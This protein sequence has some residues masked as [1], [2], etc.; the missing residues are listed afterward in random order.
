MKID[1]VDCLVSVTNDDLIDGVFI[2]PNGVASFGDFAFK[3]ATNLTQ[4]DIPEWVTSIDD[5]VFAN[6]TLLV[7]MII[8]N[9]VTEMGPSVFDNCTSLEQITISEAITIIEFHT[10]KGC[11]SLKQVN[12]PGKVNSIGLGA[13][14]GCASLEQVILPDMLTSLGD[15]VFWQCISLKRMDIPRGVSAIEDTTFYGCTSLSQVTIPD[16]VKFIGVSAF[17]GCTS[18]TKMSIPG[19]VNFIRRGAFYN[20]TSLNHMVIAYGLT[21]IGETVFKNCSSLTEIVI[22]GSVTFIGG[23]AFSGCTSLERINIIAKSA[24]EFERVRALIPPELRSK[25]RDNV[26]EHFS[27]IK[28]Y[29]NQV[30]SDEEQIG[31]EQINLSITELQSLIDSNSNLKSLQTEL[32]SLVIKCCL[33]QG[34]LESAEEYFGQHGPFTTDVAF[35]FFSALF[36]I[37][38]SEENYIK[39]HKKL[40]RLFKEYDEDLNIRIFLEQSVL[41]VLTGKRVTLEQTIKS[42]HIDRCLPYS[43]IAAHI[44]EFIGSTVNV[45]LK[46]QLN[47]I[48]D[49]LVLLTINE[50]H[51]LLSMSGLQEKFIKEYGSINVIAYE[52]LIE[53]ENIQ[54]V[55][56]YTVHGSEKNTTDAILNTLTNAIDEKIKVLKD[57][58][59]LVV[60]PLSIFQQSKKELDDPNPII[61]N[62]L[63]K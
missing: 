19:S 31:L 35:E 26:S 20:C 43:K 47:Y 9:S 38:F 12:I 58:P 25:S 44:I 62:S 32:D 54:D 27:T 30:E 24:E 53:L 16:T 60:S 1:Y 4:I 63:N 5:D 3:K 33:N 14:S 61:E 18:L 51:L 10:F 28:A 36:A 6:C 29:L 15:S 8:P 49:N 50:M 7:R 39:E 37:E 41:S 23:E 57:A 11:K 40:I 13:F 34:D 48:K 2:V 22:P 56:T 46:N 59:K 55:T 17:N 42:H 45:E 52:A 21:A